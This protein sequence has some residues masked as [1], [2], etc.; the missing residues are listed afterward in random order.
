M[1]KTHYAMTTHNHTI[2]DRSPPGLTRT[3]PSA[4]HLDGGVKH[5][6]GAPSKIRGR[7]NVTICTWNTRA[8]TAAGK[9]P[10][11]THKMDRYIWNILGLCVMKWK[12]FG[13]TTT[14][15]K[16]QGF[17]QWKRG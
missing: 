7:D 17:L 4:V 16:T 8:L 15:R 13:E 3:I 11:L 2:P 9:L 12:N 1:P 14:E 6:T 10:E 5:A